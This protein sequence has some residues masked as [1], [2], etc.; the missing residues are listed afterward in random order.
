MKKLVLC[1]MILSSL[2]V[3]SAENVV[4]DKE[5]T[6]INKETIETRGVAEEKINLDQKEV[7][8][9]EMR[10][11]SKKIKEGQENLEVK[12][13]DD[14][15]KKELASDVS[16]DSSIWKYILGVVGVIAIAVA[17]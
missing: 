4:I 10:T 3:F 1:L 5:V 8:A 9:T 7:D 12:N 6:G 16:K 13:S 15:I 11:S 17:L 14:E 2:S